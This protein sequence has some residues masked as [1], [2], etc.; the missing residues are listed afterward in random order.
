MSMQK[1]SPNDSLSR[2]LSAAFAGHMPAIYKITCVQE[3]QLR[4]KVLSADWVLKRA[5][6]DCTD[7]Y[8]RVLPE[9]KSFQR[10]E[11]LFEPGIA[12]HVEGIYES[13]RA[14]TARRSIWLRYHALEYALAAQP[15]RS[16]RVNGGSAGRDEE[17]QP[18]VAISGDTSFITISLDPAFDGIQHSREEVH[19]WLTQ[20]RAC[21]Y[22]L[23]Y[24][25]RAFAIRAP[26]EDILEVLR[27][28]EQARADLKATK[29]DLAKFG[30]YRDFALEK[31]RLS[32]RTIPVAPPLVEGE[33]EFL[34]CRGGVIWTATGRTKVP[35][36]GRAVQL[37]VISFYPSIMMSET[38]LPN[39]QPVAVM[40]PAD[41]FASAAV[42]PKFGLYRA[43]VVVTGPGAKLWLSQSCAGVSYYTSTDLGTARLL[44]SVPGGS[45]SITLANDGLP[46]GLQY[47]GAH[48][49][50]REAFEGYVR[51]LKPLK[52]RGAP[53]GKR[54]LNML[55]GALGQ[56]QVKRVTLGEGLEAKDLPPGE[57]IGCQPQADGSVVYE[58]APGPGEARFRGPYPRWGP[59][60]TA[61]GRQRMVKMVLGA[62]VLDRVVRCHTDGFI[63]SVPELKGCP[64]ATIPPCLQ[65][66]Y[67]HVGTEFGQ[68][69]LEHRGQVG[70][71]GLRKPHWATPR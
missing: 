4:G 66:I 68:L 32:S 40:L 39:C 43:T 24:D 5:L 23:L 35:W 3:N 14:A 6:S 16:K 8:G 67:K 17:V 70:F 71:Q 27:E 41:A 54:L 2:A 64:A 46:N 61:A 52:E 51:D 69:R 36:C 63:L 31:F 22:Q 65:G 25:R 29:L 53:A 49:K 57:M 50:A 45:G 30:S 58:F 19:A 21:P 38:R 48:V 9:A 13:Q 7:L 15:G 10:L 56:K 60:I 55:W 28:Y 62:G 18:R 47:L 59:F 12:I 37:D 34:R 11:T 42:Y 20:P 33:A 1:H 26:R 44:M